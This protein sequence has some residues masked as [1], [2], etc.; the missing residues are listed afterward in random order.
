[1]L[2]RLR[3]GDSIKLLP[4]FCVNVLAGWR[5]SWHIAARSVIN[6]DTFKILFVH[7][8]LVATSRLLREVQ[9]LVCFGWF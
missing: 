4:M 1:M 9:L 2:V 8:L 6:F 3:S 7:L 5:A